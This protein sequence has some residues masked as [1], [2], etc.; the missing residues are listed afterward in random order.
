MPPPSSLDQLTNDLIKAYVPIVALAPGWGQLTSGAYAVYPELGLPQPQRP[1]PAAYIYLAGQTRDM[2]EGTG[3]MFDIS[4][5][6]IRIIGGPIT[7]GSVGS[8]G[9]P[10]PPEI[11]VY[12]MVTAT[13]NQ[14]SYRRFL[15][16]PITKTPFRY[17]DPANKLVIGQ[18]GRIQGFN[19][20]DQ[21]TYVGLE[22]P[23]TI[24][25]TFDIGRFS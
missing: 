9:L 8:T 16:D 23:T 20:S 17:I 5:I 25:L 4:E 3:L 12:K 14:L 13:K 24:G 1:F 7:P 15:E 2:R 18:A 21:G 22:I 10:D 19:Y 6:R 11:L